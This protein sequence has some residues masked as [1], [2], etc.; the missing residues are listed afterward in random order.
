MPMT[1]GIV[2]RIDAPLGADRGAE[3]SVGG[4][5]PSVFLN[6]RF[7]RQSMTGVQR[8]SSEIRAGDRSARRRRPLAGNRCSRAS[9]RPSRTVGG[10]ATSYRHLRVREV[11]RM[12]GHLWE[13][14]ELPGAARGGILV[15]L[16]N[17][18][19][20]LAGR[21]AGGG[22]PRCQRI[23]HTEVLF[24]ALPRLVQDACSEGWCGPERTSSRFRNSLA[25]ASPLAFASIPH[26]SR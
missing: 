10:P 7:L 2:R 9:T 18:A 21:A 24:T 13:Q 14:V 15:N 5:T 22:Y 25:S 16:G 4:M 6:G 19:P 17:T 20:V 23:R 3:R 8:F 12:R 1:P 26:V 11:G